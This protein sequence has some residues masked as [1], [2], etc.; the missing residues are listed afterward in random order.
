M[1]LLRRVLKLQA[2]LWALFG[3]AMA[4]VPVAVLELLGQPVPLEGAWL[5][6]FGVASLVL[7][8]LIVLVSQRLDDVWWW[9]W[10]F[11]AL[12][13]GT[14]TVLLLNAVIGVPQGASAWAWWTLGIVH[15]ALGAL[16]LIGIGRAGQDKPM[17]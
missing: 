12:E 8:M 17:V 2:A 1:T 7:A 16:V 10:A 15:L 5:R 9:S 6:M 14:A 13:A 3:L 4:A 11:A